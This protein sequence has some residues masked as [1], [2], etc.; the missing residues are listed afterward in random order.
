MTAGDN[1]GGNDPDVFAAAFTRRDCKNADARSTQ[2]EGGECRPSKSASRRGVFARWNS[3]CT[4]LALPA[5]SRGRPPG[6][7]GCARLFCLRLQSEDTVGN[8][9]EL[10]LSRTRHRPL[11]RRPLIARRGGEWDFMF[12]EQAHVSA[13]PARDFQR[14]HDVGNH[15][16]VLKEEAFDRVVARSPIEPGETCV[17]HTAKVR[18]SAAG[19]TVG[20]APPNHRV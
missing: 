14:H 2:I 5:S 8:D 16:R 19:E 6:N 7:T 18:R 17:I 13:F 1:C 9:A 10:L 12:D 3:R 11:K 4:S 20:D 15:Q